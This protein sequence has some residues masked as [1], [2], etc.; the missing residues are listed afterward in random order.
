MSNEKLELFNALNQG[1]FAT[2]D[3]L[4]KKGYSVEHATYIKKYYLDYD[5]PDRSYTAEFDLLPAAF[6]ARRLDIANFLLS[7]GA[8]FNRVANKCY[9]IIAGSSPE[10]AYDALQ[11]ILKYTTKNTLLY[12]QFHNPEGNLLHFISQKIA[13]FFEKTKN[14][15]ND[16][17]ITY[18]NNYYNHP[19]FDN[20]QISNKHQLIFQFSLEQLQ[21][22]FAPYLLDSI[23]V[24]MPNASG[25]TPLHQAIKHGHA[26]MTE[27]LMQTQ[28]VDLTIFDKNGK[29]AIEL[30]EKNPELLAILAPNLQPGEDNVMSNFNSQRNFFQPVNP[31]PAI[32]N[33]PPTYQSAMGFDHK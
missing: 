12:T 7:H 23:L 10:Y 28:L 13:Y 8:N 27:W 19:Q 32:I 29:T 11:I 3:N 26:A 5:G 6:S 25:D 24:N 21:T 16:K 1:D 15:D 22:L 31:N 2:A 14:F 17:H 20:N 4:V 9:Q 18:G 30:A 33:P